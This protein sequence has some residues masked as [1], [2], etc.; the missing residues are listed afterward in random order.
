M[1]S[2]LL[3]VLHFG[4]LSLKNFLSLNENLKKLENNNNQTDIKLRYVQDNQR[5]ALKGS[6]LLNSLLKYRYCAT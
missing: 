4:L 3:F 5:K 2:F 6:L 1:D